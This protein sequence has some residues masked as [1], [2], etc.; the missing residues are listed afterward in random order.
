[1]N[2]AP[3]FIE[4]RRDVIQ[5]TVH[6]QAERR[7]RHFGLGSKVDELGIRL[8]FTGYL[9]GVMAG[10][11]AKRKV[12]SRPKMFIELQLTKRH[13]DNFRFGDFVCL[14][15]NAIGIRFNRIKDGFVSPRV[16]YGRFHWK[17]E[18]SELVYRLFTRYL[19]LKVGELTTWNPVV[20]DWI[21]R[22][23]KYF[24]ICFLQGLAGSDGYVH[25]EN[26]QVHLIVSPNAELVARILDSLGIRFS[27]TQ[28]KGLDIIKISVNDAVRL[29]IFNPHVKS[30]RFDFVQQMASAKRLRRGRWPG[31]LAS[32]VE[33]LAQGSLTTREIMMRILEEYNLL[34]RAS[35]IRRHARTV[36][37]K[38]LSA[39]KGINRLFGRGLMGP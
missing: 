8:A 2:R 37:S 12:S 21:L 25:F 22:A 10:D 33:D 32:R 1:M 20:L 6:V 14:C 19:G 39:D 18:N 24:R 15:G 27:S 30:Y 28:S 29:P 35:S 7:A 4:L 31:W 38:P 16:P 5:A 11:A 26:Q 23:P 3:T 13:P 34:I 17:S 36:A 9:L